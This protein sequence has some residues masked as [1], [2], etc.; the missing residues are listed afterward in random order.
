MTARILI[1]DDAEGSRRVLEAKLTAE[2]YQVTTAA[3]G[4]SA[5]E[6]AAREPPDIILLDLIM[7]GLDGFQVCRLLKADDNLKRI[8]V[9]L[10]TAVDSQ[11]ARLEGFE[12]GADEFLSKPIDDLV[13]FARLRSLARLKVMIDELGEHEESSRRMGVTPM[14]GSRLS[15]SGG[16]ILVVDDDRVQAEALS[17]D[18]SVE[19]RP[20]IETDP[21]QALISARGP[22]DLAVINV[23]SRGFDALRLVAQ[24]RSGEHSRQAPIL[25][26]VDPK[27]RGRLLRALDLGVNDLLPK[28]FDPLELR[29]RVRAL[30]RRKRYADYLRDA[31]A[32]SF[33]MAVIDP[34]TGLNNRRYMMGQ[35]D[36]L[37][38]RSAPGAEPVSLLMVDI[39]DFKRVNDTWGHVLGDDVLREVAIRLAASVRAIDLPCR[40]GGEEFVVVMPATR[41]SDAERV[42]ERIRD[43]I[44]DKVIVSG[45]QE[46]PISVSVGVSASDGP[47]DRPESLLRRADEALYQAKSAGRNR[48]VIHTPRS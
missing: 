47:D 14:P 19:H 40:F 31:V 32:Q 33:E 17:E 36:A 28:P 22:I 20:V 3:D 43:A 9:V 30:I 48:V 35:L 1:V 23:A 29:V 26:V 11:E 42:A 38:E 10:L 46:I 5:L 8:P 18:L 27:D 15:A 7:P 34:L 37:F 25:A 6:I 12:A 16:R 2:Y 44:S 45:D 4:A 21:Q 41:L 39:D 13:L 24:L